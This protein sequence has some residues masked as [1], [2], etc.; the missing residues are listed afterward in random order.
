M[1]II[2]Y[3]QPRCG[4]CVMMKE[5]LDFLKYE[6]TIVDIKNSS[7]ALNFMKEQGHT[8]VPQLYAYDFHINQKDTYEYTSEELNNLI[9]EAKGKHW[10]WQDSGIEQGI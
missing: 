1:S 6:Y 9:L 8:T 5:M 4:Y 10:P 7:E 2:L 3:I